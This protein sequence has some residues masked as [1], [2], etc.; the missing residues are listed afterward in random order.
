MHGVLG[1]WPYYLQIVALPREK[2]ESQKGSQSHILASWSKT[3]APIGA[4][5]EAKKIQIWPWKF[6]MALALLEHF[7]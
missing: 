1:I 6:Q 5:L 4:I 2:D 3:R 7:W